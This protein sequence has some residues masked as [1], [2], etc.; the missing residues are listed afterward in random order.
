M[1][2][3]SNPNFEPEP[4]S[5]Q[6]LN[7]RA[8]CAS[9]QSGRGTLDYS[10]VATEGRPCWIDDPALNDE[11][12]RAKLKWESKLTGQQVDRVRHKDGLTAK[13]RQKLLEQFEEYWEFRKELDNS[14]TC[15]KWELLK[16][17]L[18]DVI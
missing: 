1:C 16:E 2:F 18:K 7:Q 8:L 15:D 3:A 12:E 17:L 5:P 11:R 6:A 4:L 9:Y 13:G 10:F 14:P